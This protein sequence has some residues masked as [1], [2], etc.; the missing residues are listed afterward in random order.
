MNSLKTQENQ[1]EEKSLA[2][3]DAK[4]TLMSVVKHGSHVAVLKEIKGDGPLGTVLLD[5]A[6][7]IMRCKG[8]GQTLGDGNT[9]YG[10]PFQSGCGFCNGE[11]EDHDAPKGE[12]CPFEI[13]MYED[14]F[15][16]YCDLVDP[17][18]TNI[19]L[20]SLIKDICMLELF[21]TRAQRGMA[22][23]QTVVEQVTIGVDQN[24]VGIEKPEISANLRAYQSL[25]KDKLKMLESMGLTPKSR[26]QIGG[27]ISKDPSTFAAE[28]VGMYLQIQRKIQLAK[29]GGTDNDKRPVG[30]GILPADA[31]SGD[32]KLSGVESS[33]SDGDRNENVVDVDYEDVTG[34]KQ[35]SDVRQNNA[36]ETHNK[37]D[38]SDA[39]S[40]P[41][42]S[43]L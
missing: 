3:M 39:S 19:S 12:L 38:G 18:R 5:A 17:K 42:I 26:S 29:N 11:I 35:R 6:S 13:V 24:G 15:E 22:I 36:T 10:C 30:Q 37:D 25:L 21:V 23:S 2:K 14:R 33:G 8:I 20:M 28:L 27:T 34:D 9:I 31:E 7:G 32:P 4:R 43:Q 16:N 41:W 1:T 40:Q